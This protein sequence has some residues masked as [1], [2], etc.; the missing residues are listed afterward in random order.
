MEL[1]VEVVLVVEDV[2]PG[3]VT[4]LRSLLNKALIC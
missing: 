2:D 1:E 4:A 3:I